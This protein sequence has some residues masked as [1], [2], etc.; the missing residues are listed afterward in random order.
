MNPCIPGLYPTVSQYHGPYLSNWTSRTK[1][2]V[3]NRK[4]RKVDNVKANEC[5]KTYIKE[6]NNDQDMN[7]QIK[8]V[9]EYAGLTYSTALKRDLPFGILK[10]TFSRKFDVDATFQHQKTK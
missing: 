5:E 3:K 6:R 10:E 7:K 9:I 4:I 2:A 8:I 1:T